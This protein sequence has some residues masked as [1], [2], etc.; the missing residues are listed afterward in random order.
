MSETLTPDICVIGAGSGGLTVAAVAAGFG[1]SVVLIER[2]KMGGD[3]LNVGCVPSKALLAAGKHAAMASKAGRFGIQMSQPMIDF[4]KV[5]DHVHDVI[6][7]IAPNDSV[8][9]FEAMGVKVVKGEASFVN[10]N[11]V[12]VGDTLIKARRYVIATG[13]RPAIP[14][15]EG[16]QDVNYLTNE[17]IFDL[18]DAPHHLMIIGGGPIGMEL[19]QAHRRLGCQVTVLEAGDILGREDREAARLVRDTLTS[20]GV[21]IIEK[22]KVQK[23]KK[24]DSDRDIIVAY[25]TEDAQHEVSGS[26]L[27]VATG[28]APNI[29]TMN[30]DAAGIRSEKS[31]IR[32]NKGLRTSNKKVYAVGDVTG[33]L[34]FTHVAGYQGSLVTRALLFRLPIK[35]DPQLMPRTTYTEPEVASIGLD[36][37]SVFQQHKDAK[38][39]RWSYHENDRAQAERTTE[40]FIKVFT[41]AKGKILGAVI[42]GAQAGD[43]IALWALALAKGMTV[44]DL[45]SITPA[46]PTLAEISK[47][48]AVEFYRPT[49]TNPKVRKLIGWLRKLG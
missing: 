18:M 32:V 39:L 21:T 22:A 44:R 13:S 7:S 10:K 37:E 46:Y 47:R 41:T 24:V 1:V 2:D 35:Y 25:E 20:E 31:G 43:M 4:G 36:E 23:V 34:Q 9:R 15:I 29:E 48:A 11:T 27:L 12:K 5:H 30:L 28:R 45:T 8:E 40:G 16:L 19:A 6:A 17:T 42:V 26:H 33:G 14:P 38:I 49:L 3:C